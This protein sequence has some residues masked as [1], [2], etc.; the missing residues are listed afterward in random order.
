MEKIIFTFS[1]SLYTN[2]CFEKLVVSN[3]QNYWSRR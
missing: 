1:L 2:S 3:S